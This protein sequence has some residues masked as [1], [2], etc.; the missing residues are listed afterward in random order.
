MPMR[1]LFF[2][3]SSVG[4]AT[5]TIFLDLP[6]QLSIKILTPL[7]SCATN[8][9]RISMSSKGDRAI[10]A[11]HVEISAAEANAT[12]FVCASSWSLVKSV[13]IYMLSTAIFVH[14][15]LIEKKTDFPGKSFSPSL[16]AL[17]II[18]KSISL[19]SPLRR[20]LVKSFGTFVSG[21][22]IAYR[23]LTPLAWRFSI[24]RSL[25]GTA[26]TV[27]ELSSRIITSAPSRY[28]AIFIVCDTYRDNSIKA[29]NARREV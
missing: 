15:D 13:I 6:V 29:E 9:A 22:V 12:N 20:K 10:I 1:A 25:V 18:L 5:S 17:W 2:S 14:K 24:R 8:K 21:L 19:F 27:R 28:T 26:S 23:S 3:N 16:V 11:S 7:K 4:D